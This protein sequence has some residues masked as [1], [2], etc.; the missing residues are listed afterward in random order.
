MTGIFLVRLCAVLAMLAGTQAPAWSQGA[1]PGVAR[2]APAPPSSTPA[3]VLPPASAGRPTLILKPGD[4]V[5][6]DEVMLPAKPAAVLSGTS[7]WEEGFGNLKNAFRRIEE[8]LVRAG[9]APAGRPLTLFLETEDLS[10]RYDAMIPV[11][12]AP[13]GR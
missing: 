2:S 7:T 9:M 8:E 5:N 13:Q 12:Q 6:V 4:P 10:F 3:Q 1:S 11:A